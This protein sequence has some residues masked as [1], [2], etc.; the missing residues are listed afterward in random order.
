MMICRGYPYTHA[1]RSFE[2]VSRLCQNQL[3]SAKKIAALNQVR[4][5]PQSALTARILG[6]ALA[7]RSQRV[8]AKAAD[9]CS[10]LGASQLLPDLLQ[11][12]RR[13]FVNPLKKDPGCLAKTAIATALVRL[14]CQEVEP[15]RQ[16]VRYQQFEPVW[17]GEQDTA[18]Q[19][20]AVCAAGMAGC[21]TC[22]EALNIFADLLADPC[23]PARLGAV[24]AIASLGRW[25]GVPLLRLKLLNGDTDAEVLGECCSALIDLASSEGAALVMQLLSSRDTDV[26]IQAALALGETHTQEALEP[27][28]S[29]YET[30]RD[31]S[32]RGILLTC[33]GLLRSTES[34]AF[35]LSLI[36]ETDENTAMDA[37]RALAPCRMDGEVCQQVQ[38]LVELRGSAKL[39]QVY[40]RE[41]K[42]ID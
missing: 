23:T 5:D 16:G 34:R 8:V 19:L 13:M 33:I 40:G 15:F 22:M 42:A 29:C 18:G 10:E 32:V 37:L 25:E 38:Q 14:D 28:R 41:F 9:L 39:K 30:E 35:L 4:A 27:L 1:G 20:R 12:Y 3:R 17:N 11:V 24:R 36:P 31:P 2:C 7:D 6:T 26:R 21:A